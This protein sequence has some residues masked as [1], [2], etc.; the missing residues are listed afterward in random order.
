[1]NSTVHCEA[2]MMTLRLAPES[3]PPALSLPSHLVAYIDLSTCQQ[4]LRD[5]TWEKLLQ[6]QIPKL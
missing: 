1:M 6:K 2:K 5:H 4:S 3:R